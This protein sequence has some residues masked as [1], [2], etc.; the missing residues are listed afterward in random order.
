MEKT[1]NKTKQNKT[2]TPD[3]KSKGLG[4][5]LPRPSFLN[6][7]KVTLEIPLS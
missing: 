2:K 1:T 7:Q 4:T 6:I 5:Q 3:T